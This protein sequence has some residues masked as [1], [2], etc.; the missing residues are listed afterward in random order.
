MPTPD[1]SL[2]SRRVVAQGMLAAA[3]LCLL[4]AAARGRH[5]AA[6]DDDHESNGRG[7]GRGRGGDQP[8]NVPLAA[9]IPPDAHVVSIV[10]DDADGFS[11]ATLTIDAGAIVAFANTHRDE[12]TATGA[13]IDSGIIGPGAVVTVTMSTPGEFRY[14]C[15]F[16]PEMTGLIRVRDAAGNVPVASAEAVSGSAVTID[17]LAFDP[18]RIA[19]AP[20]ATVTWANDDTVPHTVTATDGAFDSGILEPGGTFSF[21]FD[22]PGGFTYHCLLHPT[23]TGEVQA[24]DVPASTDAAASPVPAASVAGL[25]SLFLAPQDA[26]PGYQ[27]LLQLT[28][29]G[30]ATASLAPL[31]ATEAPTAGVAL[32][33]WRT[34]DA[35]VSVTLVA[36]TATEEDLPGGTV[37]IDLELDLDSDGAAKGTW[38]LGSAPGS[39]EGEVTGVRVSLAAP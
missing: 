6:Q 37:R 27:A 36:L 5:A 14:A 10:N 20:G 11:P 24:G 26:A 39:A 23:M 9:E 21:A 16:H 2:I 32:G 7:R 1:S 13:G 25:W 17:S 15:Q 31:T 22:Q 3:G 12:H 18:P 34:R 4:T 19:V 38:S 30:D 33:E 35:L 8:D 29:D 28:A